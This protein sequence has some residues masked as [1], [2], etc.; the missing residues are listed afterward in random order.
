[1][2]TKEAWPNPCPV[3]G[4][5]DDHAAWR[6]G[7]FAAGGFGDLCPHPA[8]PGHGTGCECL[9]PP[10]RFASL[11]DPVT[12]TCQHYPEGCWKCRLRKR[13]RWP[14]PYRHFNC[15]PERGFPGVPL[16][17]ELGGDSDS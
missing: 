7:F 13:V 16:M 4:A 10:F 3:C 6:R 1:V 17:S 2:P 15:G 14:R 8:E 9:I 12:W 5:E 11:S